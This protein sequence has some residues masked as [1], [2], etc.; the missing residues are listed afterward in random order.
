MIYYFE[1]DSRF[2]ILELTKDLFGKCCITKTWGS[3]KT[4]W[5]RSAEIELSSNQDPRQVILKL[6]SKRITRG[7]KLSQGKF[8]SGSR[9]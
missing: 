3:L 5:Q 7:Y 2:Y 8:G 6:V 4:N 9:I 1:K